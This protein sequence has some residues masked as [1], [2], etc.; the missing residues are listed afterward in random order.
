MTSLERLGE[1][2]VR[3]NGLSDDLKQISINLGRVEGAVINSS[4]PELLHQLSDIQ[5]R[6]SFIEAHLMYSPK[7]EALRSA[8]RQAGT[9]VVGSDKKQKRLR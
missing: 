9:R 8:E 6:L 4:N 1:L 5:R 2:S 3:V 7:D